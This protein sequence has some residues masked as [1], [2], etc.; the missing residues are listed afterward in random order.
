VAFSRDNTATEVVVVDAPPSPYPTTVPSLSLAPSSSPTECALKISSQLQMIDLQFED[1]TLPK[2]A[3]DGRNMV[4]VVEDSISLAVNIIFY[5]LTNDGW[6]I[7]NAFEEEESAASVALS[8]KTAL[9]GF[10]Y[11]SRF[12]G[13]V[14]VYEQNG[15]GF[16]EKMDEPFIPSDE[17]YGRTEQFGNSLD[18]DGDLACV[19]DRGNTYFYRRHGTKWLEFD[20]RTV[21]Q[22]TECSIAGDITLTLTIAVGY[23]DS[24]R[25]SILQLYKYD[26][27]LGKVVPLQDPIVVPR[28]PAMHL[29]H[30]H[31]VYR[32][33]ED[34]VLI[35]RREETNQTFTFQ[36]QVN[37]SF[38]SVD[39]FGISAPYPSALDKDILVVGGIN[40]THIFSETNGD[41]EEVITLG[42]L[43]VYALS[44]R[45]LLATTPD[46]GVHAFNIEGCAPTPTQMPSLSI[47]PTACY[48]IEIVIDYDQ[49]PQ[50]TSW[51][52]RRNGMDGDFVSLKSYK[53]LD[54]GAP[55]Y[56]ESICLQEGEYEF[57][58]YDT[59]TDS[60]IGYGDNGI[61]CG[62]Y[63]EGH[64]N[65]TSPNGALIAEG[66]EFEREESTRFS[67]PFVPAPSGV[68]SPAPSQAPSSSLS[69][70]ETCFWTEIAVYYSRCS[71]KESSWE[72]R[73]ADINGDSLLLTS[74]SAGT[75]LQVDEK[76]ISAVHIE[77]SAFE[78]SVNGVLCYC[79]AGTNQCECQDEVCLIERG[80]KQDYGSAFHEKV[81]N[82]EGGGGLAAILYN[83]VEGS[84][85]N[86]NPT[87][88]G[89]E[90]SASIPA[91]F[92]SQTDGEYLL[93]H[94]L[95][96]VVAVTASDPLFFN[97]NTLTSHR[98]CLL[99]GEYEF[100]RT[101]SA[102]SHYNVT[103]SNGALI[104]KYNWGENPKRFSLPF[105][106]MTTITPSL[107]PSEAPSSI[108]SSDSPS[109]SQPPSVSLPP[110]DSPSLSQPL[111]VS[112]SPSE[113]CV[114]IEI[115]V[116]YDSYPGE[117]SWELQRV[118]IN[119]DTHL[120]E[121]YYAVDGDTSN[122]VPMCLQEGEYE[123]T[124][125]DSF[126]DGMC[127]EKGEGHYNVTTSNGYLI[128][129]GGEFEYEETTRFSIPFVPAPSAVPSLAHSQAP[130]SSLPPSDSPSL[131]HSQTPSSSSS[132][133]MSLQP[134]TTPSTSSSP[135][136]SPSRSISPTMTA[137]PSPTPPTY[138]PTS[139]PTLYPTNTPTTVGNTPQTRSPSSSPSEKMTPLPSQI[140]SSSIAPTACYLIDVAII[141]D[142]GPVQSSWELQRIS[143]SGDSALVKSYQEAN[144]IA[145][146]YSESMCLPSGEYE[147]TMYDSAGD[148]ICCDWGDGHYNVTTSNGTL[149]AHGGAFESE[150]TTRFSLPIVPS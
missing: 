66:G 52:I 10:P 73:R 149:I 65:V 37:F 112:L 116:D 9:V 67:L 69:P 55:S 97:A 22:N 92:I 109:R 26:Q 126:G 74:Q 83:N 82:C 150:E 114:W 138:L 79:G 30:D 15:F 13:V 47:A 4:V 58:I 44:G 134:S 127:C 140:V 23:H 33:G 50:Q 75:K 115:A 61:C 86:W 17:S 46:G 31:L 88:G 8:G 106:P 28:F 99:E 51:E 70:S 105:V 143:T 94:G 110:S 59:G 87:L 76:L 147:F 77:Y 53:E 100:T 81:A 122:T 123:F 142:W 1:P 125:Y 84:I 96:E 27:D 3:V 11:A 16:W 35:Y 121:S 93:E 148:G 6:V 18:I 128:A 130:S 102:I 141:Y 2:V 7:E 48:E 133:S 89:W 38:D 39:I 5:S 20:N 104:A 40:H 91:V 19:V 29:S 117:S 56:T 95:G 63:G 64:Y 103:S 72:L 111:S 71:T 43:Y 85:S 24:N 21:T 108:S 14:Y 132:P 146:S 34:N 135:S 36:Q 54:G 62:Y 145:R 78:T 137:A 42:P 120:V 129:E 25:G 60:A 80:A 101:N 119:G 124:I 98:I 32:T 139:T 136:T 68:P 12:A 118:D 107:F 113:T 41:W 144:W 45:D 49:L 90:N 131:A 57:I